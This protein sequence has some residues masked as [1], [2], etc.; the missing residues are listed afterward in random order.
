MS[1]TII[2]AI[3]GPN[4]MPSLLG[5]DILDDFALF[6]ERR[7]QRVLLLDAGEAESLLD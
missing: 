5:R 7:T 3:P 2:D 1:I 6:M 4:S